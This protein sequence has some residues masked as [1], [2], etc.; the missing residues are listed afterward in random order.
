MKL[1]LMVGDHSK[2]GIMSITLKDSSHITDSLNGLGDNGQPLKTIIKHKM[3]GGPTRTKI[4]ITDHNTGEV[5][6]EICNKILVPGSQ[7]TACKQF[8]L[9]PVVNF[10]TY[11]TDLDLD[12][13]YEEWSEEPKNPPI[14]CLWCAGRDG[15]GTSPNEVFIV[16]NTDRIEP[17]DDILPFRYVNIDDDLD[18]DLRDVYFGKRTNATTG[19]ISYFFKKFDSNPQLH[20]VYTDGTEVTSDMWNIVTTQ[21]V[22][23]YVEMRLAVSRLDF[24]D[25]FEEKL[26]WD[27]ADISTI[28]L[29]TAWYD[30]FEEGEHVYKF[31]QDIIPFS[32]FNFK[33]EDLRDL[34]RALDFTYQV[35]Y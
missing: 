16:S 29:V 2:G 35:F 17:V 4:V 1:G 28:S 23:I 20:V 7:V 22:E 33:A 18:P 25:Y 32:K 10:P 6:G 21:A 30:E 34:T 14:T 26:G 15:F 11:N 19:K 5:L 27:N 13:S 8:G 24:R 31:Y 12:N 9:D 3:S